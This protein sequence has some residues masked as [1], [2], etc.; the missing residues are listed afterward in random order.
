[1]CVH[2]L[3][4]QVLSE[5]LVVVEGF[6]VAELRVPVLLLDI[7]VVH[8]LEAVQLAKGGFPFELSLVLLG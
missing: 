2:L 6:L 3:L 5:P 7:Q 8:A 4:R 1:M